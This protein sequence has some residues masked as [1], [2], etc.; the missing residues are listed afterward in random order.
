MIF[1]VNGNFPGNAFIQTSS[2][3][4]HSANIKDLFFSQFTTSICKLKC[5]EKIV[6]RNFMAKNYDFTIFLPKNVFDFQAMLKCCSN[7]LYYKAK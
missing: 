6:S 1:K 5:G 2:K 3:I 4:A 7:D